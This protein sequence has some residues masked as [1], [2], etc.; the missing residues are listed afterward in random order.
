M[1]GNAQEWVADWYDKDHYSRSVF[2][3]PHGPDSG[4]F[5][6]LRDGSFLDY[7]WLGRCAYRAGGYPISRHWI[8]GFRVVVAPGP[9]SP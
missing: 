1:A 3:N 2:S 6:V 7:Q 5:R 4:S 8:R 9:S